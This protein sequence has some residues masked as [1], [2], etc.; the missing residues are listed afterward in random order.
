[1]REIFTSGSVGRAPGNRCLYP[2]ADVVRGVDLCAWSFLP[3]IAHKSPPHT[4]PLTAALGLNKVRSGIHSFVQYPYNFN[5][6]IVN[7]VI[8]NHM[9]CDWEFSIAR[10]YVTT[11]RPYVR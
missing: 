11:V 2:E 10:L 3:F 9:A 5:Q 7:R 6:L 8:K 1:M 4:T